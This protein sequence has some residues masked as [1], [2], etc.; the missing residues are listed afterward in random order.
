MKGALDLHVDVATVWREILSDVREKVSEKRYNL[1]FKNTVGLSLD[2]HTL[3]VGVRGTIM[4]HLLDKQYK[5]LVA[6]TA[7]ARL[8][9]EVDVAFVVDGELFRTKRREE[10]EAGRRLLEEAAPERAAPFEVERYALDNFVTGPCNE[11]AYNAALEVVSDPGNAYNPLFIHGGVGLGKTHLLVG[12][13]VALGL[14]RR[15]HIEYVS[16]EVFT[17]RFLFALTNRTLDAFRSCYRKAR[18][19]VIDDIHFLANKTHTQEEFLNTYNALSRGRC[20]IVM[21]SDSPPKLIGK[22]KEGLVTR[23]LSGL[24]VKLDKPSF[25]TRLKI[26]RHKCARRRFEIPETVAEFA[27]RNV[28]GSVRELEGAVNSLVAYANLSRRQIDVNGARQALRGLIEWHCRPVRLPE[29]DAVITAW[30]GLNE[31]DLRGRSRTRPISRAR[32]LAMYLARTLGNFSHAEIGAYFGGRNHSSVSAAVKNI[33][34]MVEQ[35]A[36]FAK[37]V[38]VLK[39]EFGR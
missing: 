22:L 39:A 15:E 16:A 30:S 32:H 6:E 23:F 36:D 2:D 31:G 10:Q 11:V 37:E 28:K 12:I 17:N 27:A 8:G 24:V 20:Q 9:R 3:V 21:A 34:G 19:L 14:H 35:D 1:W 38:A 26:V 33:S 25:A 7:A 13:A 29:I 5:Q 18:L 4:A